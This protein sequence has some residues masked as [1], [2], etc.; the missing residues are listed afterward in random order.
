LPRWPQL[1]CG[2]RYKPDHRMHV[3]PLAGVLLLIGV[4]CFWRFWWPH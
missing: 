4:A 3:L 1:S 2:I